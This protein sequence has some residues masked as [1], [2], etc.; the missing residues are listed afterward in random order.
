M[1][2]QTFTVFSVP[3][4][5]SAATLLS[6]DLVYNKNANCMISSKGFLLAL[7]AVLSE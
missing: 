3:Y 5:S 1:F 6:L 7:A 4:S 2:I